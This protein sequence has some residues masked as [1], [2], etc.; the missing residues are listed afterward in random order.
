MEY[1]PAQTTTT[2][3]GLAA[4]IDAIVTVTDAIGCTVIDTIQTTEPPVLTATLTKV[5]VSCFGGTD[6]SATVTAVGGLGHTLTCGTL[7][8]FKQQQQQQT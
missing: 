6:G 7:I 3:T 5:D 2:A 4:N 1:P 8:L